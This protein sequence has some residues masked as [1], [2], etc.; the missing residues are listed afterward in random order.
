MVGNAFSPGIG[1]NSRAKTTKNNITRL[2]KESGDV[3][4]PP[5]KN[6]INVL[7]LS[8][9]Q[10]SLHDYNIKPT[11]LKSSTL[12]VRPKSAFNK[13]HS[14]QVNDGPLQIQIKIQEVETIPSTAH[15]SKNKSYLDV[16]SS[17]NNSSV[18]S[19]THSISNNSPG[20][21]GNTEKAVIKLRV[22]KK[23]PARFLTTEQRD[24]I[25]K[26]KPKKEIIHPHNKLDLTYKA[27]ENDKEHLINE[28]LYRKF[29]KHK[30]MKKLI[31]NKDED[32]DWD[33]RTPGS[34]SPVQKVRFDDNV[35]YS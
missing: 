5:K 35:V 11:Y 29:Q 1:K 32:E 25:T 30:I 14:K 8:Q 31:I 34:M 9:D 27:V 3:K 26:P 15:K 10:Y 13:F 6:N 2:G 21:L 20:P 24:Q 18:N 16:E 33:W 22:P 12:S 17:T 19:R 28:I 7:R 4:S 23:N